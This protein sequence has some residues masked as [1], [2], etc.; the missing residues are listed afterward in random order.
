MTRHLKFYSGILFLIAP[1]VFF[2]CK[3]D[4]G[5]SSTSSKIDPAL[6]GVWY[7]PAY[8]VG[9][10]ISGDSSARTLVVDSFGKL[11]YAP[12]QLDS[13]PL[14]LSLVEAKNGNLKAYIYY[15]ESG[16]ED[17]ILTPGTYALSNDGNNLSITVPDPRFPGQQVTIEFKRT[18]VGANVEQLFAFSQKKPRVILPRIGFV[19]PLY[20]YS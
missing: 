16:K 20:K 17:T 12:S 2:G 9:F 8:A 19:F 7:A 6:I 10:E 1:I 18:T 3:K 13:I 5:V 14:A 15:M 4:N 11:I